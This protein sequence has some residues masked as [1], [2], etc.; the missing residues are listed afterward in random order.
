[1]FMRDGAEMWTSLPEKK[2]ETINL[3]MTFLT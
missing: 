1:M 3:F 2:L